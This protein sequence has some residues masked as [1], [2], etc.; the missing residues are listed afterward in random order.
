MEEEKEKKATPKPSNLIKLVS[1][2]QE[3]KVFQP[4]EHST[5]S[6][7]SRAHANGNHKWFAA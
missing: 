5:E 4:L 7:G 1:A 2:A 6:E 3:Q